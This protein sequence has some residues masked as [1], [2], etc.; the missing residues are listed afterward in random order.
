MQSI[1]LGILKAGCA[2]LA[3]DPELP[4]ARKEF[5]L[6][7]SGATVLIA[8]EMNNVQT[9]DTTAAVISISDGM[10]FGIHAAFGSTMHSQGHQWTWD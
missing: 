7:D 8:D 5:I 4:Q 2:F 6:K 3:L 1:S 10:Q 9:G